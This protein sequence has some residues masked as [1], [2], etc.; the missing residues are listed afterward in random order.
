MKKFTKQMLVAVAIVLGTTNAARA[1]S[2]E[3]NP[4]T[5]SGLYL[6]S[7]SGFNI[8]ATGE[9]IPKVLAEFIRFNGDGTFTVPGG[10]VVIGGVKLPPPPGPPGIGA[11]TLD[12]NCIGTLS[13]NPQLTFDIFVFPKGDELVMVQTTQPPALGLPVMQ[14]TVVRVSK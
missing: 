14:G 11:Y 1:D 8:V 9:H 3:C 13:F 4:G 10:T 12:P 2:K 5:L 7:A 6:F